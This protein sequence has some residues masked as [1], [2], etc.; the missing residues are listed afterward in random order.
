V[1]W[2]GASETEKDCID[3]SVGRISDRAYLRATSASS[4]TPGSPQRP[5][6]V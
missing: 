6:F 4:T 5:I 3:A 1:S 2:L